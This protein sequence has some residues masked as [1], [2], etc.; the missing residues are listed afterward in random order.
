ME[1]TSKKISRRRSSLSRMT[2]IIF[3]VLPTIMEQVVE[4]TIQ[5]MR[6]STINIEAQ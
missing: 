2:L 1:M 6:T 5:Q 4:H 3:S